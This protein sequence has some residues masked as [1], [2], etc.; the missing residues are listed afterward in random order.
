MPA[1]EDAQAELIRTA[2]V[3]VA[4][5]ASLVRETRSAIRSAS[6]LMRHAAPRV[7][8]EDWTPGMRAGTARAFGELEVAGRAAD[9]LA[10]DITSTAFSLATASGHGSELG[11]STP[12][13]QLA[14]DAGEAEVL[15]R[16][17]DATARSADLAEAARSAVDRAAVLVREAVGGVWHEDWQQRV[18]AD[19]ALVGVRAAARGAGALAVETASARRHLTAATGRV[20]L[21]DIEGHQRQSGGG[22]SA[23]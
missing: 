6:T 5:A 2:I 20:A 15:G 16:A 23:A 21:V 12:E 8:H 22:G 4:R 11:L 3:S 17:V 14:P 13:D 19:A 18:Q 9:R 1:D 10:A 7:R